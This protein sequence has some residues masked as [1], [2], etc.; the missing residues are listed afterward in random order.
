[1]PALQISGAAT[2][3]PAS[4]VRIEP[5]ASWQAIQNAKPPVAAASPANFNLKASPFKAT[6]FNQAKPTTQKAWA[7]NNPPQAQHPSSR[8]LLAA[9]MA[10]EPSSFLDAAGNEVG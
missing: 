5:G 1:M 10:Q 6:A 8:A 2:P 9:I 3:P 4:S 7:F